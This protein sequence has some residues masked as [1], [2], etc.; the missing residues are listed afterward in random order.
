M[1][2]GVVGLVV[3]I[4]FVAIFLPHDIAKGICIG[5][6]LYA[7]AVYI[8]LKSL[9]IAKSRIIII[10]VMLFFAQYAFV[11]FGLPK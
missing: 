8:A 11:M 7:Y 4:D 2:V 6:T 9:Q 10:C 5:V 1:A 3:V